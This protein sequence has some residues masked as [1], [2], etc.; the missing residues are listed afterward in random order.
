[1]KKAIIVMLAL[2]LN[3]NVFAGDTMA[4]HGEAI[5]L[6]YV[7]IFIVSGVY[8]TTG[9]G[10]ATVVGASLAVSVTQKDIQA[11]KQIAKLLINDVQEFYQSG[12]MSLNLQ[13]SVKGLKAEDTSLSDSEALDLL[14]SAALE[15]LAE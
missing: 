2:V 7:G 13:A 10:V 8:A 9:P 14:N 15:L 1:M 6:S 3:A 5:G 12:S 4:K 11:R